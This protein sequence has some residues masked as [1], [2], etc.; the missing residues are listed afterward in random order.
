MR[1]LPLWLLL[2]SV[3]SAEAHEVRPAYLEV[4]QL[5]AN[6]F[7]VLWKT[8]MQGDLRLALSPAFSGPTEVLTPVVTRRTGDAAVQSWRFRAGQPLRGQTL[9]IVGLEATMTD[10]LVQ[11]EFADGT[12]WSKRLLPAQPAAEIPKQQSRWSV[13]GEYLGLGVEHILSGIDH[14]LFV[15]ALLLITKG[16]WK[17][18]KSITAF[19]VAHSITLALAT[20][21]LV[22]VPQAPV[23]AVIALSIVFVSAEIL[24][25]RQ[26]RQSVATSSP[27]L[28]A[29]AFGLLHGFGFAGALT[30]IGLPKG[31]IPQALLFFNLGVEAGQLMFIG[32]VIPVLYLA[33]LVA[34]NLSVRID[35]VASYAIGTIAMYWVIERTLA[36]LGS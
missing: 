32:G 11:M 9:S 7:T 16:G 1:W 17:L 30:K 24:R 36:F 13:C 20:L 34:S 31:M 6:E 22:H 12:S 23:E 25:T 28:I 27:W 29:F 2:C 21:G 5:K 3:L 33:D 10:V 14:L 35:R 15:L 18:A 8:P 4:R 19:T 26:G